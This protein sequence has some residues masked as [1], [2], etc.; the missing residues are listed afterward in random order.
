MADL[1]GGSVGSV[2]PPFHPALAGGVH[3]HA[4]TLDLTYAARALKPPWRIKVACICSIH[5]P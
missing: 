1:G 2:D 3:F 5:S 4:Y